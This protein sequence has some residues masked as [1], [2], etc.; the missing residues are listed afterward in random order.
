MLM[1]FAADVNSVPTTIRGS[2]CGK[3]LGDATQRRR[4][5]RHGPRRRTDPAL[6]ADTLRQPNQREAQSPRQR[7]QAPQPDK[8]L[9]RL[10]EPV[11]HVE[12]AHPD[13]PRREPGVMGWL[14]LFPPADDKDQPQRDDNKRAQ[15]FDRRVKRPG[16]NPLARQPQVNQDADGNDGNDA[17]KQPPLTARALC[18]NRS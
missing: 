8:H 6:P 16:L 2:D 7:R 14:R 17:G 12:H 11:E 15:D 18:A 9:A 1:N 3:R 4:A 5:N 10:S 13:Q